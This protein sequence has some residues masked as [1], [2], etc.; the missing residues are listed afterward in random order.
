ML[1]V[2][3]RM[4]I[5]ESHI[6]MG[7]SKIQRS[8]VITSAHEL[9]F[10]VLTFSFSFLVLSFS[11][12]V[13][14]F[15]FLDLFYLHSR[16]QYKK[17]DFLDGRS[18]RHFLDFSEGQREYTIDPSSLSMGHPWNRSKSIF[19][20]CYIATSIHTFLHRYI[21]TRCYIATLL[22]RYI[23]TFRGEFFYCPLFS[24]FLV[25]SGGIFE[26][27]CMWCMEG[28]SG[29]NSVKLRTDNICSS[30]R[31]R[32]SHPGVWNIDELKL[33]IL[34]YIFLTLQR[35]TDVFILVQITDIGQ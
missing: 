12:L 10:F 24:N 11:F 29:N 2:L 9:E 3:V 32:P 1:M 5:W 23:A 30:L 7:T 31:Y 28:L 14:P 34:I 16:N 20:H 6:S 35:G 26:L 21:D 19:L 17:I 15:C 4:R 13:F 33:H 8:V 27:R 18:C 22:H 25:S